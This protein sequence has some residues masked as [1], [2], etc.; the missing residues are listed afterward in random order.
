MQPVSV[1]AVGV[2]TS[3]HSSVATVWIAVIL[4]W[5]FV[6]SILNASWFNRSSIL[7]V[8]YMK[9]S[10]LPSYYFMISRWFACAG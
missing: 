10:L 2:Q 8:E 9:S 7:A 4:Q 1:L 5:S 6:R 3:M